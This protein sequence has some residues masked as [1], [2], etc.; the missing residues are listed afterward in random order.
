MNTKLRPRQ[1]K[2]LEKKYNTKHSILSHSVLVQSEP[3][4][5]SKYIKECFRTL[6]VKMYMIVNWTYNTNRRIIECYSAL[7]EEGEVEH[8]NGVRSIS[9]KLS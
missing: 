4:Y 9:L 1:H 7:Y 3:S 5:V 8:I 6:H 2:S